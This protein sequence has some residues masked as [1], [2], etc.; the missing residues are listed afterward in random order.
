MVQLE[1]VTEELL[2]RKGEASQQQEEWKKI[3]RDIESLCMEM[4]EQVEWIKHFMLGGEARQTQRLVLVTSHV[5]ETQKEENHVDDTREIETQK[6]DIHD[7]VHN[8]RIKATQGQKG[9]TEEQTPDFNSHHDG[10]TSSSE[11]RERNPEHNCHVDECRGFTNHDVIIHERSDDGNTGSTERRD[12]KRK[13]VA[14]V[15]V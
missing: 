11:G 3:K 13:M 15:E 2:E 6:E 7:V 10:P 1:M 9:E 12:E 14:I 5:V 8:G 4:H